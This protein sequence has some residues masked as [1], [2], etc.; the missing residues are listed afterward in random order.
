MQLQDKQLIR[1][2]REEFQL[3]RLLPNLTMGLV[4][5][6][7]DA[8]YAISFAALIFSGVLSPYASTG[9]GLALLSVA[10][11]SIVI[12]LTS[13]LS[14]M[15]TS[16]QEAPTAIVALT[17]SQIVTQMPAASISETLFTVMAAI[18]LINLLT[19]IF[20]FVFG[21]LKLGN[22]PRF[23][24]YPVVG[25]F[26]AG[27]G[28]LLTQ[29]AISLMTDFPLDMA[30]L[31]QLFQPNH[32]IQWLPGLGFAILVLLILRRYS[33]ALIMP[34]LILSA[35]ALFYLILAVTHTSIATARTSGLF[36]DPFPEGGLWQPLPLSGFLQTNWQAIG[37]QT[38]QILT[39]PLITVLAVLLK[40]TG[41]ELATKQD[42]DLNCELQAAGA[43]N[44]A[45]GLAGGLIIGFQSLSLSTLSYAKIGIKSRMVGL[46]KA[47][48]C[49]LLLFAG[50]AIISYFPK[51]VLGGMLLFLGLDYLVEWLYDAWFKL[52]K[53]DYL[54][55]VLI[56]M[57]IGA[58]GL[59]EGVAV[60]L[61]VAI[62]L[63]VI[64]Y[65][66]VKVTKH[67]LSGATYPSHAARSWQQRRFLQTEGN[68][69][70]ILELQGFLFFGTANKLVEQ[71][72]LRL[73]Q[74]PSVK[75]VVLSFQAVTGL[76]S[77]AVLSF[78]KLQQVAQ[79]QQ[80]DLVF[81]NVSPTIQRQL[82]QGN[83]LQERFCQLFPDLDRGIEWCENQILEEIPQ[84]RRR[85]LPLALQLDELFPNADYIPVFMDYL[86][87]LTV[88][89]GQVL[90]QSG[91]AAHALYLIET[92]EVTV[93]LQLESGQTH[94]IQSLGAGNLVGETDFFS[95]ALYQTSAIVN[96][97]SA[98]Y[99]LSQTALQQLQQDHLEVA[100]MFQQFV[101]RWVSE[102]LSS[103]YK[104]ITD[105]L[106]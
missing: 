33:H 100:A 20:C 51:P 99:C 75:S 49:I 29:G 8:I 40:A 55:V 16:L 18:V 87:E 47:L 83:C 35:I 17:A 4:A 36:L 97:P 44:L 30:H 66:Q 46:F 96:Q 104:E 31:P 65:S 2:L 19:G 68:Q 105:L 76:D 101:I 24:P 7:I 53:I 50:G 85:A 63:F 78:S 91:D 60:G 26:L 38:G 23:I 88:E 72:R 98:L 54:M 32:L 73:R 27:T 34:G 79:Q 59:L 69:I 3:R 21:R 22:F 10:I 89:A 64:N 61:V 13:S 5:T 70:Y 67:V 42:L 1:Q 43:A 6:I 37:A 41:I 82:Q 77:S 45:S 93:L 86:E 15:L 92:G 28:W 71:I 25:G 52:P 106:K 56:L 14:G 95:Q 94:R 81:T 57:V 80:F 48:L 39:V 103:T 62:V 74:L 58:V 84:R 102:R 11:T 9:I 90:F 12:A